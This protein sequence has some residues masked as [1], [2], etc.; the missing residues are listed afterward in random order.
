MGG[1][2][3][4]TDLPRIP[5]LLQS[6]QGPAGGADLLQ[7]LQTGI[8]DLVEIDVIR[9]EVA[10]AGLDV[11]GHSLPVPAHGLGCQDELVP[12]AL[13]GPADELLADAVASGGIYVVDASGLHCVQQ[14]SGGLRVDPLDGD[15]PQP[16][17]GYLKAG[18]A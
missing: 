3:D 14:L 12:A 6:L 13:D 7:L 16:Q 8:V 10:K 17:P 5:G 2:S 4:V 15:A 9:A 1:Q 11:P 18:L